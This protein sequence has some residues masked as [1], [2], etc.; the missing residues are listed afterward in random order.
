MLPMNEAIPMYTGDKVSE[1]LGD[2]DRQGT[3][4]IRQDIP[5]PFTLCAVILRG[6]TNDS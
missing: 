3:L 1:M 5:L 4:Y 2:W 6:V